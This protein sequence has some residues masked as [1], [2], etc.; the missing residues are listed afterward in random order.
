V[1]TAGT[2]VISYT[3]KG[4]GGCSDFVTTTTI[5]V[6]GTPEAT[7]SY[8]PI[9][10]SN[11]AV[12]V[13][14][15]GTQGG[16]FSSTTGLTINAATGVITASTSTAGNYVVTYSIAV[17]TPCPGFTT[18]TN[19]TV[20]KAPTATIAYA[21]AN[22]CNV[23]NSTNTPNPKVNVT[24][25]G[26]TGGTYSISPSTGLPIN[27]VTGTIDPSGAV[28]GTYTI[29]YTIA[30]AGGCTVFVTTTQI[31]IN[32]TPT[33]SIKYPA[34]SYCGGIATPQAVTF[35]GTTGGTYSSTQGLSIN[36][37]TGEINPSLSLPGTYTVTY[38][39]QPSAPCPGFATTTTV[40]IDDSPVITFSSLIQ[41]ICSGGTAV[42]KPSSTVANTV[43]TWSVAGSLPAGV[44]GVTSGTTSD[45]NASISLSFTN[46]SS[47]S[48]PITIHVIPTN[49]TQNP[50]DGA[51]IDLTLIVNPIPAALVIDTFKYCMHTPAEA[52]T[53]NAA[54]GKHC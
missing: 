17:S 8:P 47:I 45:P 29:S 49:P 34:S 41:S 37:I 40:T 48:Q 36:S 14:L 2:Y 10:T 32:S 13:Q 39:I 4:S 35:S 19:V 1:R 6:N 52:L 15:T 38:T 12:S 20:T 3:I 43:Y 42:F 44:T 51:P 18:T 33:A 5:T 31:T 50:C 16:S 54:A 22:L 27:T 28:A 24:L 23:V 53:V 7:I 21:A 9:C 30:A 26:N 46:T 25:T 11:N